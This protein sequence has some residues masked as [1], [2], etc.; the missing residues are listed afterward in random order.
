LELSPGDWI[1]IYAAAVGTA[2]LIWQ[3]I[4][5]RRETRPRIRVS[6]PA[7]DNRPLIFTGGSHE[8]DSVWDTL[9][10]DVVNVGQVR[11][12]VDS[13][14]VERPVPYPARFVS[15][16]TDG[17]GQATLE[18]G[19]KTVYQVAMSE[20]EDDEADR[21]T[22]VH[23]VVRLASGEEY[24]TDEV[25]LAWPRSRPPAAPRLRLRR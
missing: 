7:I 18:P 3:A 17:D 10:L 21:T 1:A 11:L 13:V 16:T 15:M 12:T 22:P 14:Q 5:R 24:W 23:L 6:R 4:V 20:I 25:S 8:E 2:S 9:I 19:G